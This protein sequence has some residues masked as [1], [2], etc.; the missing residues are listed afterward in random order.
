[1]CSVCCTSLREY[2]GA[3]LSY[4]VAGVVSDWIVDFM[5]SGDR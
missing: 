3:L 1:M 2:R 5:E 4:S